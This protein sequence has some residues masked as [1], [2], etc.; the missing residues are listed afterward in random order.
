M[1]LAM[2]TVLLFGLAPA[3]QLVRRDRIDSLR[4]VSKAAGEVS[5]NTWLGDVFVGAQVALSLILLVGAALLMRSFISV[6]RVD[7]GVDPKTVAIAAPVFQDADYRDFNR[8]RHLMDEAE[9]RLLT[10]PGVRSVGQSSG[11]PIVFGGAA[12][13][14]GGVSRGLQQAVRAVAS[15][16]SEGM[17]DAAGYRILQGRWLTD[18]DMAGNRNVAVINQTLARALDLADSPLGATVAL[19]W[20]KTP[21]V[22]EVVGVLQDTPNQGMRLPV[23]AAIH[24]PLTTFQATGQLVVRAHGSIAGLVGSLRQELG[25]ALPSARYV[26]LQP[27]DVFVAPEL[28]AHRFA[29]ALLG[30]FAVAGLALALIGLYAVMSYA[31]A[32][33][34]YEFGIRMALG[35]RGPQMMR[36]VVARGAAIVAIG[37]AA[38]TAGSVM[39]SRVLVSYLGSISVRDPLTYGAAIASLAV[40]ALV[41]ILIPAARAVR[42]D[43]ARA[44]RHE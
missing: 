38:G 10:V 7:T 20:G 8:L 43:P 22:Y 31:V 14:V 41:A 19:H 2:F 26:F 12:V 32:R 33:R 6:F 4:G 21:T 16:D 24:V 27:L 35:A 17:L 28:G 13:E 36:L 5:G 18:A 40:T 23:Q 1:G 3:W 30:A 11:T 37:M 15:G 39:A 44:L 29:L 25:R 42:I 34:N 9:R